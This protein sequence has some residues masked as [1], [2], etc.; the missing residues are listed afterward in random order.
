MRVPGGCLFWI[1]ISV[2]LTV[3]VNLFLYLL[4]GPYVGI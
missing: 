1:L 2:V 4:S 3:L